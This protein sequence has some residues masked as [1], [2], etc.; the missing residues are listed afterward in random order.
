MSD[1]N[2][3]QPSLVKDE[4]KLPA[5][6][7]V[8]LLKKNWKISRD[9]Y[10]DIRRRMVLLDSVDSGDLWVNLC[11]RFPQYQISPDT[12]YINFIKENILASIY[13]VG[14]SANLIPKGEDDKELVENLNRVMDSIWDI[15]KIPM[16]Q[17]KAGER[18]ALLNLGVTQVGWNEDLVG[19]TA[20][21]W[22]RGD[23]MVKNIDPL[24]YFRDP[25][26]QTLSDAT[27]VIT[28]EKHSLNSLQ[29]R[30]EYTER[31]I[32][33]RN[34]KSIDLQ[35]DLQEASS[36]VNVAGRS[37]ADLVRLVVHWVKIPHKTVEQFDENPSGYSIHEIH[38]IDSEFI[39]YVKENIAINMF[40]F[41]ELYC[42]EPGNKL[43]G[44]SEPSKILS[45]SI[46]ANILDSLVATHA[47]KAQRPPRVISTNSG[48]NIRQF[49]KHGNDPDKVFLVN[50]NPKDVVSY[51][52]FP[53]LPQEIHNV[54][55]R[56]DGNIKAMSGIDDKYTGKDTGSI[57]TTGGMEAM[58]AQTTMRDATKINLYE[59]YARELSRL[60]IK[61]LIVHGDLRRYTYKEPHT[62][63]LKT[64]EFDFPQVDNNIQ[65]EY[66]INI[67]N[68]LPKNRMRL[69]Q[70]ADAIMEKSMQYQDPSGQTPPLMEPEEWLSYQDFPQKEQ[71]LARMLVQR[72]ASKSEEAIQ[73][74]TLFTGLLSQGIPPEEAFEQTIQALEN[75]EM[76]AELQGG[77]GSVGNEAS[78]GTGG[79]GGSAQSRQE[80]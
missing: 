27:F 57:L 6:V 24:S 31:I 25:F 74:L 33:Y 75:P 18:A 4:L 80:G 55:A 9:A 26:S 17:Q 76:A 23:V 70:S 67:S 35:E 29:T 52:Q 14:K 36:D 47:F 72:T 7:S 66:A 34:H 42:N 63:T 45:S 3:K 51:I 38:T 11:K 78:M 56:L 58:L 37:E 79:F 2:K 1:S 73:T 13:T 44:V 15:L 12:N 30:K 39:L 59:D 54:I 5:G 19:G 64:I 21:H 10:T 71:I 77:L 16:Y 49:A 40:P 8:D 68:Q 22:Y 43:V 69:A 53:P 41:S 20:G 28:Q 48:I 50:G 65:F 61:S 46:T 62:N 32:A 60:V